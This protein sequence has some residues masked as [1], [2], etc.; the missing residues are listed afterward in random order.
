LYL[1]NQVLHNRPGVLAENANATITMNRSVFNDMITQKASALKKV[2][3][4]DIHIA[5]SQSDYADF[6]S[7]IAAPFRASFNI[8]EP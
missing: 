7:M 6:Q 3:S 2:L 5:G 8:I 4:G 1:I